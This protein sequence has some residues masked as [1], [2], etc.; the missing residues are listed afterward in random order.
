M[1]RILII[2]DDR[3]S[4]DSMAMLLSL[5][6]Y[7]CE[8]AASGHE[9]LDIAP[10]F[11]PAIVFVDIGMPGMDGMETARRLK[12]QNAGYT[13]IALSGYD[14]KALGKRSEDAGFDRHL[15]KPVQFDSL[16]ATINAT[17]VYSD[18]APAPE[19]G[20]RVG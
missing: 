15:M 20:A 4:A 16:V 6:G 2:D 13:L 5:H 11:R 14:P 1:Q 9:A 7:E 10:E 12:R 17:Q 3:D 19:K 8:T 18:S